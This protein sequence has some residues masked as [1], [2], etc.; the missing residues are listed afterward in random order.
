MLKMGH[1]GKVC[2]V[3]LAMDH[4]VSAGEGNLHIGQQTSEGLG[5]EG[6]GLADH[7]WNP[8]SAP[9]GHVLAN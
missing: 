7:T 9:V 1:S 8:N 2:A 5:Q 3:L 4:A 6:V